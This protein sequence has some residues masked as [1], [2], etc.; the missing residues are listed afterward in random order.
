MTRQTLITMQPAPVVDGHAP[1]GSEMTRLPYPVHAW[2]SDGR[3]PRDLGGY[4]EP[5]RIIGF[6][7]AE[8]RDQHRLDLPWNVAV[9]RPDLA[10]G[11]FIVCEMPNGEGQLL[12]SPVDTI[13][14][15]EFDRTETISGPLD[16]PV[17]SAWR[18]AGWQ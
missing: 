5:K 12:T 18:R 6:T 8:G 17:D 3:V 2:A 9:Q 4:T 14:A 15:R 7:S 11:M 13:E 10:K 1:D 16:A